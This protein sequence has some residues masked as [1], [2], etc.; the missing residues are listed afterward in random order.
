MTYRCPLHW[1]GFASY[2]S[3][4]LQIREQTAFNTR[5]S[6]K[7]WAA[8]TEELWFGPRDSPCWQLSRP[9]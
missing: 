6:L 4:T 2:Q 9:R 7:V 1:R 3:S 8:Q 5:S